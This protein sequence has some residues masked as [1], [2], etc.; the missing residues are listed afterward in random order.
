M[1]KSFKMVLNWLLCMSL[2]LRYSMLTVD[3]ILKKSCFL[4]IKIATTQEPFELES[5]KKWQSVFL[6][7]IYKCTNIEENKKWC[8]ILPNFVWFDKT[9]R[10]NPGTSN[11][12]TWR[13]SETKVSE[14]N[15]ISY[16]D[17]ATARS[18]RFPD[19]PRT[20][21]QS[22]LQLAA[23]ECHGPGLDST[24]GNRSHRHE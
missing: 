17:E 13:K 12:D 5:W 18:L 11:S 15:S 7:E 9:G 4:W 2:E 23:T 1:L 24:S 3:I 14:H 19:R 6:S 8:Y 10:P 20:L 16:W 21:L 22:I